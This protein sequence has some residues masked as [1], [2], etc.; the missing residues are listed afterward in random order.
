MDGAQS[1]PHMKVDVQDFNADFFAMSGHKLCGPIG[2]GALYGKRA[3]LFE[4]GTVS[5]G[6]AVGM[7]A[8]KR[9]GIITFTL[10]GVHPHDIASLLS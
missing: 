1:T 3:L 7:A 4:A 6:D 9:C 5:A 10:D 2:I 8:A